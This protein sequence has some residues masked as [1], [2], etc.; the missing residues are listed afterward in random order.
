[1]GHRLRAVYVTSVGANIIVVGG[2]WRR[3]K[4]SSVTRRL[5]NRLF[6]VWQ[7]IG[8]KLMPMGA[9]NFYPIAQGKQAIE[10][11]EKAI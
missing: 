10:K 1:M 9:A 8:I 11:S 6:C 7:R 4:A 3:A 5:V 2:C